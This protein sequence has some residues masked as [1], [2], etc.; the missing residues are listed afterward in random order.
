MMKSQH[1]SDFQRDYIHVS[2]VILREY[3][4]K[5][6]RETDLLSIRKGHHYE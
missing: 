1:Y 3:F 4:F 6:L 2:E 5:R